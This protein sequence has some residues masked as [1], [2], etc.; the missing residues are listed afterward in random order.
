M[1]PA[2]I[3]SIKNEEK[4]IGFNL[5][6]YYN[7]GIRNFYITFNCTTDNSVDVVREFE[8][9]NP[10]AIVKTFIDSSPTYNLIERLNYMSDV[11]YVDGCNWIIPVDADEILKLYNYNLL[12]ALAPHNKHEYGY[13]VCRWC[14]YVPM[15]SDDKSDVNYFSQ[16]QYREPRCRPQSK[17]FAKWHPDMKWGTGHHLVVSKRKKIANAHKIFVAHFPNREYEQLKNKMLTI[18]K[19][20][21]LKYGANSETLQV[22]QYK[23]A[24]EKG[25]QY[26]IDLWDRLQNGRESRK[27]D[28]VYDPIPKELFYKGCDISKVNKNFKLPDATLLSGHGEEKT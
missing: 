15:Q 1:R 16:W 3:T 24:L 7:I 23:E 11:A 14:D 13:I 25:E 17:V 20:F 26:F 12:D 22:K 19:G 5:Q 9:I 6:Y 10:D 28:F 2:Y 27:S 4:L 18:G 8:R 21:S